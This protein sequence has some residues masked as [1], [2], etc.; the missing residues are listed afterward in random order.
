MR[1][2]ALVDTHDTVLQHSATSQ[3]PSLTPRALRRRYFFSL[4]RLSVL[5]LCLYTISTG[6]GTIRPACA[7]R[8]SYVFGLLLF[9]GLVTSLALYT[10]HAIRATRLDETTVYTCGVVLYIIFMLVVLAETLNNSKVLKAQ[11]LMIREQGINP[12]TCPAW[13]KYAL[14]RALRRSTA[15]YLTLH[16]V[17]TIVQFH[18]MRWAWQEF[19]FNLVWEALQLAVAL[20]VGW[21]L[22]ATGRPNLYVTLEEHLPPTAVRSPLLATD[23]DLTDAQVAEGGD[24]WQETLQIPPPPERPAIGE[25]LFGWLE[26]GGDAASTSTREMAEAKPEAEVELETGAPAAESA[27]RREEEREVELKRWS[28]E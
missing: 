13:A 21:K 20:F 1:S 14:F 25:V 26:T 22:R 11:L 15:I 6:A 23:V 9:C 10:P 8:R 2:A 28:E 5:L 24:T 17:L 19:F 12:R 3:L 7:C 27:E 18:D 4:G 16:C